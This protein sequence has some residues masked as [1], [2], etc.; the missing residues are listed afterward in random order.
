MACLTGQQS[1]LLQPPRRLTEVGRVSMRPWQLQWRAPS[2]HVC[3]GWA[4]SMPRAHM[5]LMYSAAKPK[6]VSRTPPSLASC[7]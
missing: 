3:H 1:L 5:L 6:G 4:V 2:K 7:R